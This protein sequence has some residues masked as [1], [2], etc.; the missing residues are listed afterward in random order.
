MTL[1]IEKNTIEGKMNRLKQKLNGVII[2]FNDVKESIN[3]FFTGWISYMQGTD[4]TQA[5]IKDMYRNK[6]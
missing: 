1:E 4:R 3:D 2:S 6:R 5:D